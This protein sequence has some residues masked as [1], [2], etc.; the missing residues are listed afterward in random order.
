MVQLRKLFHNGNDQI[1]I[2]FG[3]DDELK[4]KV[5]SIGARWSQTH[6]CWYVLYDKEKGRS[7]I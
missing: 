5:K 4:N 6:K 2:Y 1:G 3:F 7:I